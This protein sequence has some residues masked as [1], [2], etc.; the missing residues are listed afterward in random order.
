[1]NVE[2]LLGGRLP[3][4]I[5][6]CLTSLNSVQGITDTLNS[7][8][9]ALDAV[10]LTIN[11]LPTPYASCLPHLC[12][13]RSVAAQ[14]HPLMLQ[15][16]T[17]VTTTAD[18]NCMYHALSRV[19]CGSEQLSVVFRLLA[20]YAVVKYRHVMIN[21]LHDAFP[22]QTHD[23]NERKCNT[24]LVSALTIGD[25]GSD[26]HLFLLSLLLDRPIFLYFT[27]YENDNGMR[28]L[29]LADCSDVTEF[30][31]RFLARD[32][33]TTRHVQN[34][35]SVNR[36]LL[37]SGDVTTLPHLPLAIFLGHNHFTALLFVSSS[38]VQH[39]P[40]PFTRVLAD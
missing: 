25:W 29:T 11:A 27:F 26:F 3:Q 24:L 17:P 12:V 23:E 5:L 40:I 2:R 9:T 39:I 37:A 38:V 16:F 14:C 33:G 10:A 1:M 30:A 21:A 34:A 35:T 19:V 8:N 22:L 31:Q 20:A 32:V 36:A 28:S 4:S 7:M 15:T 18:G 6:S 13:A